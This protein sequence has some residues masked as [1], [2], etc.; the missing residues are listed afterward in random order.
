MKDKIR[1]ILREGIV[2][3]KIN[4]IAI[5]DFDGTLKFDFY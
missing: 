5:F 3:D 2:D 1:M 4:R